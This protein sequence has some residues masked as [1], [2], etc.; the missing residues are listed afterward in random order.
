MSICVELHLEGRSVAIIGGG[1]VA[2]RKCR[3]FLENGACVTVTAPYIC[4]EIKES[5]AVCREE[6]FAFE[7]PEA[8]CL[9]YA[10]TDDPVLNHEIV[11][12]CGRRGILCGSAQKDT[13]VSFSSMTRKE[14][15]KATVAVTTGGIAPALNKEILTACAHCVEEHYSRRLGFLSRILEGVGEDAYRKLRPTISLWHEEKL[16]CAARIAEADRVRVEVLHGCSDRKLLE[17]EL[18]RFMNERKEEGEYALYCFSS[19]HI[20]KKCRETYPGL[21]SLDEILFLVQKLGQ[22]A[23]SFE[24]LFVGQGV[25]CGSVMDKC[26]SAGN[27]L[28]VCP[29]ERLLGEWVK[30]EIGVHQDQVCL[31]VS[32]EKFPWL[33]NLCAECG[34]AA[35]GM[36]EEIPELTK[37]RVLLV[38]LFIG[39]GRHFEK[40]VLAGEGSLAERLRQMG[41]EVSADSRSLISRFHKM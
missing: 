16:S 17:E 26:A 36:R 15:G 4:E 41:Y 8:V 7:L 2:A 11:E 21:F 22:T 13:D 3:H 9:V 34:A 23:F 32:H 31:F 12:Y 30:Q 28:P 18:P 27:V 1:R 10:A 6:A 19:A 29:G 37:K 33:K 40:D 35:M 39:R 38:P 24:P 5:G 25:C 20:Y 14:C